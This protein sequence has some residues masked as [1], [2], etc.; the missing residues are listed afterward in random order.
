MYRTQPHLPIDITLGLAPQNTTAPNTSKFVQKIRKWA[1]WA[2]KKAEAFQAKKAQC[3][4]KKYDKWSKAA[5][6]EIGDMVLVHVTAF[7]GHHK[8]QDR[9]ENRECVVEKWPYPDLPV[10]VLWPRDGEGCS[11]TLHR[12][13]LL[14]IN[15][16][17]GQDEKDAPVTGVENN[18]TSTPASPGDSEP[19]DAG[20]S[21]MVTPSAAGSTSQGS[22]DQ[23]VPLRHG[24]QKTQNWLPWRYHTFSLQA[25]TR[26]PNA[27]D[28]WA[29][30]HVI[31]SL[32]NAFWG[33]TVWTH[34]TITSKFCQAPP[35]LA[36][37]VIPSM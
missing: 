35:I 3:H 22:P 13:Y 11:W 18:N 27:W 7:K 20:P 2:Q 26:A 30:L 4:K 5:A 28:T 14:P 23:P 25:G 17:I 6:L 8:I 12:N 21:G 37:R 9:W 33:R 10:Y 1:K 24:T 31:S 32:Y 34:S 19:A 36:F 16:N 15:S 29:G